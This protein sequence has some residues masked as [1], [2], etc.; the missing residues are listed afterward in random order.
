MVFYPAFREDTMLCFDREEEENRLRDVVGPV[1]R[2]HV[3]PQLRVGGVA[4][5][6]HRAGIATDMRLSPQLP[7]RRS[8]RA[9]L[10][11]PANEQLQSEDEGNVLVIDE[12]EGQGVSFPRKEWNRRRFCGIVI[13]LTLYSKSAS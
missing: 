3:L 13:P 4:R 1:A 11:S 6:L 7:A 12:T 5:A 9:T 8:A 10:L 2:Q